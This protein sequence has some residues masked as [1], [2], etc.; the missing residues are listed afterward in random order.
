MTQNYAL[1]IP[2][3]VSMVMAIA[4][5]KMMEIHTVNFGIILL[6]ASE[7]ISPAVAMLASLAMKNAETS[8]EMLRTANSG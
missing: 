8:T 5:R 2:V 1:V 3:A 4:G 7:V 6:H